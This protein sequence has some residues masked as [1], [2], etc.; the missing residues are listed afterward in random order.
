MDPTSTVLRLQMVY[1]TSVE[2]KTEIFPLQMESFPC[3]SRTVENAEL[4]WQEDRQGFI[5]QKALVPSPCMLHCLPRQGN[6]V[7][8]QQIIAQLFLQ[9][10]LLCSPLICIVPVSC[11]VETRTLHI[12]KEANLN[13]LTE[14]GPQPP[15]YSL[16]FF[17]FPQEALPGNQTQSCS[18]PSFET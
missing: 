16:P 8:Q 12:N 4:E 10:T 5:L 6:K 15:A 3:N 7:G 2:Q 11:V 9:E 13:P 14:V 18:S 1:Q 17:F